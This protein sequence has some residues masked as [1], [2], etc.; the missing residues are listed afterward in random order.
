VADVQLDRTVVVRRVGDRVAAAL[1]VAQEEFHVLSGQKLHTLGGRQLQLD[2]GDV[3]RGLFQ[4]RDAAWDL[5][6]GDIA[7]A[8]LFLAS[9]LSTYVTGAQLVVDGGVLLT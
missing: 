3:R 1:A 8:V 4:R 2:D 6:D 9:D 7:R 5:L